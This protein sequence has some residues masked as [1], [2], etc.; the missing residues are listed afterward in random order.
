MPAMTG[1]RFGTNIPARCRDFDLA[2]TPFEPR[3]QPL[4]TAIHNR[5][6][7]KSNRF[8]F[9]P[10]LTYRS[11]SQSVN[12]QVSRRLHIDFAIIHKQRFL[13]RNSYPPQSMFINRSVWLDQANFR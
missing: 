11:K 8:Q 12:P 9:F 7:R 3:A 13:G 2:V 5:Q 10:K 6:D 4:I 1:A